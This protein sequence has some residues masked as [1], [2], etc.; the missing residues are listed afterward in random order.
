MYTIPLQNESE[1]DRQMLQKDIHWPDD[2]T[3]AS[4]RYGD[5]YF[6]SENGLNESRYVFLQSIHAP[7][8]W[9]NKDHFTLLENGFGTGL[10]FVMTCQAWVKTAPKNARLTYIATEKH[11]LSPTDI[12]RALSPW[13]ELDEQRDALL[14]VYG[15]RSQG[16]HH[17]TLLGGRV[18]LLLLI[19][20]SAHNLSGLEASVDALYL[21]GFT[22]KRN[23][24]MW[25]SEIFRQCARLA[26]PE[27]R[28]ATFTAAGFVRRG[29]EDAGFKIKKEPGYGAKRECMRGCFTGPSSSDLPPWYHRP[30]PL[31]Q[32]RHVAIIGGGIAG[33]TTA[34]ALQNRGY[35]VT[36]F[37]AEASSMSQ[38]SGNPAAIIDPPVTGGDTA[39]AQFSRSALFH[40]LDYY[41]A[42]M[43]NAVLSRGLNKYPARP[44]E[45][46]KFISF[47]SHPPFP[48]DFVSAGPNGAVH[49][50]ECVSLRP[51]QI[52]EALEAHLPR[53]VK[54][55]ITSLSYSEHW[56][57]TC[58]TETTPH[59]ADAI[60]ICSGPA[61]TGYP[62]TD[63][64]P[65]EPVRGQISLLEADKLPSPPEQARCG[66]GYLVPP[67]EIAGKSVLVTGATFQR[68]SL[69]NTLRPEDHEENLATLADLWPE[70]GPHLSSDCIIGGR[71]A[72]R[73]YSPD[74]LPVCGPVPDMTAYQT[75]YAD[76]HHGPRHKTFPMAPYHPHLYINSGLGARGFM[77]APLLAELISGFIAGDALPLPR[78]LIEALHPARFMVRAL[79]KAP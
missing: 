2:R 25:T 64:L 20:D 69:D 55:R 5:I 56:T 6:S 34:L 9:Q 66:A 24:D 79:R 43:P 49:F 74:H 33:L 46:E 18:T 47:L 40:A 42:H 76:L 35:Q 68:G 50:P 13:P 52:R 44:S 21:D 36:V 41:T 58:G 45:G 71:A 65:L 75:A 53:T 1:L 77:T 63:T 38:A 37:E 10:N 30:E 48:H 11:P 12:R 3:P 60:V 31:S 59:R 70:A 61:A 51:P 22:P 17:F 72:I 27:A 7:E 57:L 62:Q 26:A 8:I 28:L 32:G 39:E 19:G 14:A 67:V 73:A 29:L 54:S 78:S 15:V 4:R 16:Y 23:Q